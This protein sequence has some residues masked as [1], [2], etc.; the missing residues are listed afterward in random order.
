[1]EEP[2]T[3]GTAG[4]VY[5]AEEWRYSRA[6]I[7]PWWQRGCLRVFSGEG[8]VDFQEVSMVALKAP[9]KRTPRPT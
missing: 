7:S 5:D 1:L 9:A 3:R 2:P 4:L 8:V 6:F